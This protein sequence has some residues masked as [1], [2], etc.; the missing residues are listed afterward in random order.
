MTL[1]WACLYLSFYNRRFK[2]S[3]SLYFG[4]VRPCRAMRSGAPFLA[5]PAACLVGREVRPAGCYLMRVAAN[6]TSKQA[7][8]LFLSWVGSLPLQ[9]PLEQKVLP[10]LDTFRATASSHKNKN[11]SHWWC[12]AL[13]I[14]FKRSLSSIHSLGMA[15]GIV[16]TLQLRK[17]RLGEVE[18]HEQQAAES[19]PRVC[20]VQT[21]VP[22]NTAC[23]PPELFANLSPSHKGLSFKCK[24]KLGRSLL[25]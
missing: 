16:P 24:I 23:W 9:L 8:L 20:G 14:Q 4:P 10:G 21:H 13:G 11:N 19:A 17:V 7:C 15:A 3:R 22:S 2:K 5:G 1:N 12:Q 18:S 25:L 6:A